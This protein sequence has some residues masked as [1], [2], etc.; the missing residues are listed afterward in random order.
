MTQK[1]QATEEASPTWTLASGAD[2]REEAGPRAGGSG[3]Q[4]SKKLL[5]F[6][7]SESQ[8]RTQSLRLSGRS[9]MKSAGLH[10]G[11]LLLLLLRE[12]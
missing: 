1:E 7:S 8:G 4:R 6:Q 9:V 2:A 3:G 11:M 10:W 12:S 5:M